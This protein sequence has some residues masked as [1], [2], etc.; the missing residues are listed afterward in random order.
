MNEKDRPLLLAPRWDRL[1]RLDGG[2]RADC[3]ESESA[4]A[5][6]ELAPNPLHEAQCSACGQLCRGVARPGA[7]RGCSGS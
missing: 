2:R 7:G 3:P 1:P 5:L 4:G 6:E